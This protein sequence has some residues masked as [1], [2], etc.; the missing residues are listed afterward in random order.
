MI[1]LADILVI[2]A[3]LGFAYWGWLVGLET[4]AVAALELVACLVAAVLLHEMV[5]GLLLAGMEL[6]VGDWASQ[7]WSVL[8]AFTLI[9]WGSFAAIRQ[10]LHRKPGGEE[11]TDI[12]PLADRLGGAVAGGIG[13]AV[14][15]GGVLV[16]LSMIPF[17]AWLKPSGD[18]M[19]LDVGKTVLRVGCQFAFDQRDEGRSLPLEGEPPSRMS[20]ASASL[21]SEPWFDTDED[22]V[23]TDADRF[24][25]VDDNDLFTKDLYFLDVDADGMRRIGLVDKYVAG[26]WDAALVSE[27]RPRPD[28]KKPTPSPTATTPPTPP[29]ATTKPGETAPP[30]KPAPGGT[31]PDGAKP[32]V[33]TEPPGTKPGETKP[34]DATKPPET[35]PPETKPPATKPPET[36]P[37]EK[38]PEDD[39]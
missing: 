21:A 6:A 2:A 24:R 7:S 37:P 29:P 18:R 23:C 12:D 36:K 22:G 13:G 20:V 10:G 28:L 34:G 19:L 39:F 25:D 4:A 26:R 17:L 1:T 9:S 14:F 27:D 31:K 38:R 15:A 30:V 8:L 16:T 3:V 11:E 5:A 35:K 33:T 32:P